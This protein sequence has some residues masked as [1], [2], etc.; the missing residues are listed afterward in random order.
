MGGCPDNTGPGGCG[1]DR[2]SDGYR[3]QFSTETLTSL[4]EGKQGRFLS[5]G[6][7]PWPGRA[8]HPASTEGRLGAPW[9]A[10]GL[11]GEQHLRGG[12]AAPPRTEQIC[13]TTAETSRGE[14]Y[15]VPP[16]LSRAAFCS[17][18]SCGRALRVHQRGVHACVPARV[19]VRARACALSRGEHSAP[20]SDKAQTG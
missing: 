17:I 4:F 8:A 1:A 11:C 20:R 9:G 6:W 16:L 7:G 2:V 12:T 10:A 19:C 5:T 18:S 14:P 3:G 15:A 13:E